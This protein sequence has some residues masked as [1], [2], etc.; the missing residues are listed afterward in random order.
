MINNDFFT[1]LLD[2][3]HCKYFDNVVYRAESRKP[4]AEC[5][6]AGTSKGAPTIVS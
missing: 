4:K 6:L 5:A 1:Y 2:K 3:K